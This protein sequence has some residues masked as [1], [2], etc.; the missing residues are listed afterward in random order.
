[1]VVLGGGPARDAASTRRT[2][3]R[4]ARRIALDV[5]NRVETTDAYAN[6][7][8][9]ARLREAKLS[10]LDRGLTTELV[11]GVLRW[12]GLLD[13]L[14]TPFLDRPLTEVD[15]AVRQ[16]LRLG[17][18]QLACLSR[19]PDF[20]AVD[21]TVSLARQVGAGRAA[22]YVNAVLRRVA[23][24]PRRP[25]P[26]PVT[27][28]LAYWVG[29]GSHPAWLA[30]R[31]V[32]RLGREEAGALMAA[33][34][35]IPPL[36]VMVNRFRADAGD[37]ERT[38]RSAGLDPCGG[39]HV[40]GSFACRGAGSVHELPGFAEGMF[41]PMDEAGALPVLALDLRPG[42]QVLDACAGGGGKS[43]LIAAAVGPTGRVVALDRSP[44]AIRRLS[45]A[46]RRLGLVRVEP[47]LYDAR[48]AGRHWPDRFDRVLLDAPCTGLGTVR[49]RPEIKWRRDPGDLRRA[50]VRQ[51][52]LLDGASGAVAPGGLLI[53]STCSLEP[54]ETDDVTD[55]FLARHAEFRLQAPDS[56][57]NAFADRA[58]GGVLRAW[59]HR[60]DTD[61]FFVARLRRAPR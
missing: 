29:P 50:A 31:W 40:R 17:A 30:D 13:W 51:E 6:V 52:E 35:R 43:A 44:R 22:G 38:L 20:A 11:Y 5:L 21:E 49:R 27:E 25:D 32:R 16:L 19:V 45:E 14:I 7:L 3:G 33:N 58:R 1:L 56:A 10:R 54:E 48:D 57:L 2:A 34:N 26:D 4:S 47:T 55:A 59:P 37:V 24:A 61:G 39:C 36:T 23:E 42:H 18:Y 15:L 41:L 9:D 12:R 60:H 46:A 28:P 53:Y 8:L